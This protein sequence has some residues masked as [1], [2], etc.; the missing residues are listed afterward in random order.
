MANVLLL[1]PVE[2]DG[3]DLVPGDIIRE[4]DDK[5][6]ARLV[7]LGVGRLHIDVALEADDTPPQSNDTTQG[8]A[9]GPGG[10]ESGDEPAGDDSAG[11]V[12][13]DGAHELSPV[14]LA[15]IEAMKKDDLL[16]ALEA[17]GVKASNAE[18]KD[19]LREKLRAA[20]TA[21]VEV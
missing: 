7:R 6:A 13:G 4:L 17:M 15:E 19:A 18:T 5:A 9:A 3:E 11:A 10:D 14:E 20:R 12:Q 8:D 1:Q 21:P 2:H 16:Q